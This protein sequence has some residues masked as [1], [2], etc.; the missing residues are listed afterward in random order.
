MS[1][2]GWEL[3]LKIERKVEKEINNNIALLAQTMIVL[4]CYVRS[5]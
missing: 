2:E 1:R 5:H 3:A 4:N